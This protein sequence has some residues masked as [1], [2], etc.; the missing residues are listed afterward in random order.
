MLSRIRVIL[1]ETSHPG[2]IGAVAR[3][4][5]NMGMQR[6]Y[7]VNPLKFPDAEAD[8][9]A[10]G[11]DDVLA[12][13]RV[14]A[15]LP[16]AL[17]GCHM[18]L[19]A[20]ARMRSLSWPQLEPRQAATRLLEVVQHGDVALVFGRE[21]NGLSNEELDLCHY[22]VHIPCNPEFSSLNIAA[23]VQVL[24]YEIYSLWQSAQMTGSDEAPNPPAK[25]EDMQLFYEHLERVLIE[26][27]FLDPEKP[28]RLMRRLKRLYNR[29]QPDPQELNILR[30]ILSAVE[31]YGERVDE[32]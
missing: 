18:V 32:P 26:I 23:A 5:K 25:A 17:Q 20:S 28:R 1:V 7:L 16:E 13:A 15:G 21:R 12:N 14:V 2:N 29:A 27:D 19:G 4:M 8:A 22:L 11:A 3:A 30:G 9:R 24:T 10:S 31:K 6:L